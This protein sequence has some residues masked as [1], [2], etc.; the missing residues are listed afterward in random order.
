MRRHP[1]G[2]I[3]ASVATTAMVVFS[4]PLFLSRPA[5]AATSSGGGAVSPNAAMRSAIQG[6][7]VAGSITLPPS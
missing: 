3:A 2:L 5:N 7:P 4:G 6:S 1:A